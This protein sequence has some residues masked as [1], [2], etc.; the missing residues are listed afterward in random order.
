RQGRRG[1]RRGGEAKLAHEGRLLVVAGGAPAVN[2]RGG[3][4]EI[5]VID[6]PAPAAEVNA[7][8]VDRWR[9]V[10]EDERAAP[11]VPSPRPA[12]PR[13]PGAEKGLVERQL[14]DEALLPRCE[15]DET[16]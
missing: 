16:E 4:V 3:R 5:T 7:C 2:R 10:R 12:R 9:V 1:S 13:A 15:A 11:L 14:E 8:A 6:G